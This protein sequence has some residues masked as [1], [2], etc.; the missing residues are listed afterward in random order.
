M[1][2]V[3]V[4]SLTKFVSLPILPLI[5]ARL[6]T[7]P[8]QPKALL[9]D[10]HLTEPVNVKFEIEASDVTYENKPMVLSELDNVTSIVWLSP[11]KL[12]ANLFSI[13]GAIGFV[14]PV[15]FVVNLKYL[16]KKMKS[17]D[18]SENKFQSSILL[19]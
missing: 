3:I 4:A 14:T 13:I 18:K 6:P 17:L 7:I 16:S 10:V 11:S 15:R 12:P 19:I 9:A 8:P 5:L 1:L 2:P